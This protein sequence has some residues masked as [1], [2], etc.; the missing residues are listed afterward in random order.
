MI[1]YN[2]KL[3]SASFL[4]QNPH[5]ALSRTNGWHSCEY[6]LVAQNSSSAAVWW[7]LQKKEKNKNEKNIGHVYS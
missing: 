2:S 7:T 6:N 1:K 4:L 5:T 3:F